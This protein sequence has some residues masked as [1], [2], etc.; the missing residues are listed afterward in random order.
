M[1]SNLSLILV[2]AA[3]VF[4]GVIVSKAQTAQP[5]PTVILITIDGFPARAL[6]DLQLPMPHLRALAAAGVAAKSMR[7]INPT[8]T[9][10]N[11]TALVTGVDAS[12]HQVIAN[13]LITQSADGQAPKL[14]RVATKDK[15]VHARTLYEAAAEKG[16]TTAQVDWV[17]IMGSK[18]IN[19]AFPERPDLSDKLTSQIPEELI[20]KGLITTE[21]VNNFGKR[22]PAWHDQIWTDAAVDILEQH[23]PNLLLFHL[24]QTDG[25][26]HEYGP[27]TPA[28]YASYAYADACLGRIIDAVDKAGMRDRTTYVI[29]SDHGFASFTHTIAPNAG[30]IEQGVIRKE[31]ESLHGDA[32]VMSEGGAAELFIQNP[33][34]RAELIPKLKTYFESIEGIAHVYTNEE[35][36]K[37]GI[38]AEA[39][40]DQAPQLYLVAAPDYDFEDATTGPVSRVNAVK[41]AH[42]YLNSMPEMQALFV[43]SGAAIKKGAAVGEIDNLR[44][45]PTIAKILDLSLPDAKEQPLTEILK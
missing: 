11:H 28:A 17:A 16:L 27:L 35:A 1:N 43:A 15:L 33:Q 8:V 23:H 18:S 37:L 19:W 13:G 31:G 29:A 36:H 26:Q 20:A 3:L 12:R 45:A 44:V 10:P 2:H 41:G 9:W 40:S 7:P 42:G 14:D 5:Q 4:N 34:R 25:I 38:P 32:W 21:Q 6:L 22:E 30:L 24:L 39:D